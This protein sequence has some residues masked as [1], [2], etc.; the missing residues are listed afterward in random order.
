MEL[1]DTSLG[2]NRVQDVILDGSCGG[3]HA[4]EKTE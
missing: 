2:L 3:S 1:Y 4:A